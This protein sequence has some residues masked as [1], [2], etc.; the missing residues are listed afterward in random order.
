M[1][2]RVIQERAPLIRISITTLFIVKEDIRSNFSFSSSTD[3]LLI[4][5]NIFYILGETANVSGDQ[6]TWVDNPGQTIPNVV[7]TNNL[8]IHSEILPES[9]MII[10]SNPFVGDPEFRS[11]GGLE[12]ADYIP[13]NVLAVKK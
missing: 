10:D 2:A 5:N 3:G 13:A 1:W 8:Y 4:A 7:F 11:S 9:L 6:D 12:P